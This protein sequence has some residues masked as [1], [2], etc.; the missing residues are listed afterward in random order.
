MNHFVYSADPL[1]VDSVIGIPSQIYEQH[2]PLDV[3]ALRCLLN[4]CWQKDQREFQ[5]FACDVAKEHKSTLCGQS[6]ESC[7]ESLHSI[8]KLITAKS[9]WDTVD[10]LASNGEAMNH[11]VIANPQYVFSGCLIHVCSFF[12]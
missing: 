7:L 1:S 12:G 8:E 4:L 3:D 2:F 5:Y 9:W 11:F 6:S 10:S